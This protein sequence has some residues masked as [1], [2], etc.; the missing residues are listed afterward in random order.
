MMGETVQIMGVMEHIE[1]AGIHSGDSN[2]S[3]LPPYSLGPI[4]IETMKHY[5]EEKLCK[6]IRNT[7]ID[8][9]TICHKG[10]KVYVL[11]PILVHQEPRRLF[12][13]HIKFHI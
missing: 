1:P 10:D 8:K 12:V 7:R 5:T 2:S 4:I 13:K 9:Y 3:V 11:K 6:G